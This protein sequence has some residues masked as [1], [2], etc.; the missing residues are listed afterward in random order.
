MTTATPKFRA[1]KWFIFSAISTFLAFFLPVTIWLGNNTRF[2]KPN[3]YVIACAVILLFLCTYQGKYRATALINDFAPEKKKKLYLSG[4]KTAALI[5]YIIY[6][7]FI[8]VI[9]ASIF[10]C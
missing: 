2:G 5:A 9:I 4:I 3:P 8:P 7:A 1:I 10:W 6:L